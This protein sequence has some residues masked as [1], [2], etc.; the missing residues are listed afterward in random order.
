MEQMA[1]NSLLRFGNVSLT[2]WSA[3]LSRWVIA[4]SVWELINYDKLRWILMNGHYVGETGSLWDK[5][6][7]G[8]AFHLYIYGDRNNGRI[9]AKYLFYGYF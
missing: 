5:R 7:V 6:Q 3:K 1:Q 2:R 4:D 9:T 8:I